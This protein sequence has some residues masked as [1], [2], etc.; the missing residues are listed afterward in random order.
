MYGC[1]YLSVQNVRNV[2]YYKLLDD[3]CLSSTIGSRYCIMYNLMERFWPHVN[4]QERRSQGHEAMTEN[5]YSELHSNCF[6]VFM[7]SLRA[8]LKDFFCVAVWVQIR[9]GAFVWGFGGL[10][11]TA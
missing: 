9:Y 8:I 5:S 1:H 10:L 2:K 11:C 6:L 7:R 4:T 3:V